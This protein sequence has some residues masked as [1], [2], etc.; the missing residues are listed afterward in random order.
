MKKHFI[1]GVVTGAL[2]AGGAAFAVTYVAEPATFKILVN[3]TQFQS[4]PPALVIDGS[5]YLPLRAMGNAL[6]VPVEWNE[7]LN[8]VEVGT[9]AQNDNTATSNQNQYSRTNP[10]PI[11]TVQTYT[12]ADSKYSW[13]PGYSASIRVMEV[14]RGNK[15]DELVQAEN[16]F[17][18][19]PKEGYEYIIVKVAFSLLSA[20][21]DSSI[22]ANNF[23]FD[24]YSSNNEEYSRVSV[25]YTDKL[26]TDLY[27]GGNTEGYIIGMIKQDDAAP[28]L[29][30]GL[31]YNGGGG[32][33]FSLK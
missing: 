28:K 9:T 33:W 1:A 24:F 6:N 5:T 3:G 2:L 17:N 22:T 16:Q 18:D 19:L 12:H 31:D 10:A 4:D 15:A 20:Q 29:A 25:V 13:E 8:Q 27:V 23:D 7:I 30:Y 14:I 11:N 26:N 32:V 21:N